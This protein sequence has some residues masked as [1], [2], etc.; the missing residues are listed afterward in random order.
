[1]SA[2]LKDKVG[3]IV[4]ERI[5]NGQTIGVGTG[6]TVDAALKFLSRRIEKEGLNIKAVPSSFQTARALEQ[7]GITVL[8]QG[9][10][11][12]IDFGFDGADLIDQQ[13]WAIK[14]GGA[15]L[16][17]EKVLAVRCKTFVIIADESKFVDRLGS[18]VAVPIEVL[19]E[20]NHYVIDQIQRNFPVR[21]ITLRNAVKKHGPVITEQGN[22]VMDAVFETIEQDLEYNL[23]SIVGVI[24]SGLFTHYVSEALIA[25]Q[26][27]VRTI[28]RA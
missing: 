8:D 15:A 17:Q 27:G 13:L 23:K 6:S 18:Q 3:Q 1:M 28:K 11:G 16:L 21:S 5:S 26:T 10:S 4:V 2:T 20:A 24:D 22:L 9:Y 14:G 19:P 7:L 12:Q 25:D